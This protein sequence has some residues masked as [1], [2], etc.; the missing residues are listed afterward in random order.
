MKVLL[1]STYD[2]GHQP[3]GLA[4]PAAWLAAAGAA[5]TCND[6]AVEDL[7]EAAVA[8]AGLICIHLPMHAATRL[9]GRVVPKIKS[10][11]PSAHLCFY[12]LYAPLSQGFVELVGGGTIIGGEFESGLLALHDALVAGVKEIA[13]PAISLAKQAFLVPDRSG[14]PGLANYAYLENG[15]RHLVGYTEASRGCKHTCRHCPV[16]PVYGGNFRIVAA[17]V[18]LADI[19]NQVAAGARH[20][21]FGDPDFFNGPRHG[22]RIVEAMHR[23]FPDLTFDATIKIEHL[24]KHERDLA[25]LVACGCLFVTTAMESVD[26]KVLAALRKG[27]TRADMVAALKICRA[28][29]LILSP[30]FIPFMPWTT[31]RGY[32]DLL[33]FVAEQGLVD[34]VAPVQLSMRLLLPEKSLML[35]LPEVTDVIEG[36]D[37][38]ALSHRWSNP[39]MEVERLYVQVRDCVEQGTAEG[40]DRRQVFAGLWRIARQASGHPTDALPDFGAVA[41]VPSLSEPWYCCAEPTSGQFSRL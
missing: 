28:A 26:D 3:F 2:L 25:G 19:R 41:C 7:N 29:G 27:H 12:G 30:T 14:L 21:S 24:I 22:L 39:D 18:V 13:I 37:A 9:A 5:V 36:F 4:S 1:L 11:N 15:G 8:E 17:D 10:L 35:D 16:V 20:I 34:Q 40:Q 38:A 23:E 6:L 31:A 32:M 33:R